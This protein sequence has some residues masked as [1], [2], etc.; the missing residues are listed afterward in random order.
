MQLEVSIKVVLKLAL[1][2]VSG[3]ARQIFGYKMCSVRDLQN[4]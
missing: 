3:V 4:V 1:K 2:S